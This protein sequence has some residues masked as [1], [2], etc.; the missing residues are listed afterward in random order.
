MQARRIPAHLPVCVY[1]RTT[2]PS[3]ERG[4]DSILLH[5]ILDPE[6]CSAGQLGPHKIACTASVACTGRA[7]AVQARTPAAKPRVQVTA[8]GII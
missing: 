6:R 4:T 3:W 1:G 8:A 2:V 7:R 5:M